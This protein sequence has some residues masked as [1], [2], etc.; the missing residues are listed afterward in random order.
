[1]L[2]VATYRTA[3]E[4]GIIALGERLARELPTRGVMLRG[5]TYRTASEAETIT[6]G[7]RL[8]RGLSVRGVVLPTGNP[9][10]PGEACGDVSHGL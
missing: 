9:A 4:A 7:E 5:A 2:R 3:S 10:G 1:M 6:L 8:A